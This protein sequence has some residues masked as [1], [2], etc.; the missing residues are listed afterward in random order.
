MGNWQKERNYK[1]RKNADGT[2]DH[3]ITVD[4]TDVVVSAEVFEVYAQADR[5]E[6]YLAERDAGKLLSLD[7]LEDDGASLEQIL[8][9]HAETSEDRALR[10]FL[11]Q[12][13]LRA[14]GELTAEEQRL[15]WALVIESKTEREY[16]ALIGLS[17]KAVNKRKQKIL[18][19]L[20]DFL[21]LKSIEFREGI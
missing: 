18:K 21:V 13:A 9:T 16:G 12:E 20:S 2:V 8:Y 10:D 5:R 11:E 14:F 6:R 15:V 3:V 4:R 19:K 17:Q 7:R 1:K